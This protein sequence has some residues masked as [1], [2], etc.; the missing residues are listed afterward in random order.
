MPAHFGSRVTFPLDEPDELPDERDPLDVEP[1]DFEPPEFDPPELGRLMPAF[2]P[3]L[4]LEPEERVDGDDPLELPEPDRVDVVPPDGF[5]P[6]DG[7]LTPDDP[8]VVDDEPERV[9]V[10]RSLLP[11]VNEPRFLQ[12]SLDDSP[13]LVVD[14]VVSPER[15]ELDELI[16]APPIVVITRC[17]GSLDPAPPRRQSSLADVESLRVGGRLTG[18]SSFGAARVGFSPSL[19]VPESVFGVSRVS[20]GLAGVGRVTV[21]GRDVVP[22]LPPPVFVA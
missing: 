4:E 5:D 3:P 7:R 8:R 16:R 12:E 21:R 22:S 18:F 2:P 15:S 10:P 19:R 13:D 20:V 9:A 17:A 14:C 6:E 11:V 1:P